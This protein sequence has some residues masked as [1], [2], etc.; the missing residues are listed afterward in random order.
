MDKEKSAITDESIRSFIEKNYSKKNNKENETLEEVLEL[1]RKRALELRRIAVEVAHGE[2]LVESL[3]ED[4]K[5]RRRYGRGIFIFVI[6]YMVAVFLCLLDH[7]KYNLSE[8]VLI[9]LL[10]TTTF[11]IIGLL[12]GVVRYLFPHHKN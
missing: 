9:A 7:S 2:E 4:R 3:I 5:A 10:T 11:N 6:C 8:K 1:R 12:T